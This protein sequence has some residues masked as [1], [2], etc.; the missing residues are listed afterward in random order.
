MTTIFLIRHGQ[1]SFG[2]QNYDQLSDHGQMQSQVLGQYLSQIIADVPYAVSGSMQRHQ[3]TAQLALQQFPESTLHTDAAWNEF[4]HQQVFAQYNARFANPE[5]IKQDMAT[6]VNP[7]AFMTEI[8]NAAMKQWVDGAHDHLYTESWVGFNQRIDLAL[9]NLSSQL[10]QQQ[11]KHAVVFS[12]GGVISMII[13]KLLQLNWEETAKLI[14]KISN[15]SITTLQ[16]V[17]QGFQLVSMNEYHY[18]QT[19]KQKLATWV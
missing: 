15:A 16:F 10:I 13:A 7:T 6:A 17:D 9:D 18:L 2:Q 8:F 4:D 11:P 12:S 1:A 3:H 5:L 19:E 14:W